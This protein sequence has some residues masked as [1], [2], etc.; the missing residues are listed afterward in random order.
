MS[1]AYLCVSIDTVSDQARGWKA[2]HPTSFEGITNGVRERLHPLFERFGAKPTYLLAPEVLADATC[3][4][5]FRALAPSCELGTYL[6]HFQGDHAP[7]GER[8]ELTSLTDRFIRAFDHQ[9]QSFRGS[10]SGIGPASIGILE[11]LGYAV[12]SSV[13]P[14]VDAFHDAP[15]QPYRPDPIAPGQPGDATLLEVPI[16]I[17][18]RLLRAIPGIGRRVDARWLCP[19]RGTAAS[20]VRVAEDAM[21][22]ARRT[23]PAEPV[24]LNAMFRNVEVVPWASPYGGDEEDARGILD[25][26]RALLAFARREAIAVVGLGDVPSILASAAAQGRS[27]GA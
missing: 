6:P 8:R 19:T 21:A 12:D 22:A 2:R 14:H 16:T 9:P 13:T 11:S 27:R 7:E 10:R 4:A 20:L 3:V 24:I 18:P 17:R 25:R 5:T 15:C 1:R 26:V 23:A